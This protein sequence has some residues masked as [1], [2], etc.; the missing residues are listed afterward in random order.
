MVI[1]VSTGPFGDNVGADVQ[2]YICILTKF[3]EYWYFIAFDGGPVDT[4]IIS[5][6]GTPSSTSTPNG[7]NPG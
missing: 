5:T 7:N 3:W 2:I 1:D 4:A 6:I